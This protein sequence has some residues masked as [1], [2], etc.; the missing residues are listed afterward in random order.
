MVSRSISGSAYSR[1]P[2]VRLPDG[3]RPRGS[4]QLG[5]YARYGAA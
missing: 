3:K 1:F 2:T 4:K 5:S